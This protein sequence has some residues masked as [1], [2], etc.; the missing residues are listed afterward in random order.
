M[1]EKYGETVIGFDFSTKRV[2]KHNAAGRR[3]L[4]GDPTDPDFWQ[5]IQH[6]NRQ[7][8][9]MAILTMP[10]HRANMAAVRHLADI[11][12]HGQIAAVAHFDDQVEALRAA[13]VHAAF[14]FYSEAGL[15]FAEHAWE[16]FE[17]QQK[18]EPDNERH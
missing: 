17:S 15:G 14:N 11:D 9:M 8:R 2:E 5:R 10:K 13:G 18:S 7:S 1:R 4:F 16:M 6:L 12:F 3:V